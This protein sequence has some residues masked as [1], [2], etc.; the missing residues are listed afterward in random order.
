MD[1]NFYETVFPFKSNSFNKEFVFEKNETNDLNFFDEIKE[2]S[3]ESNEPNDDR[4]DS[5][6]NGNKSAPN[7]NSADVIGNTSSR[8]DTSENE[9]VTE[10]GV[11]EGIYS[12]KLDDDD[13]YE[14]D[15]FK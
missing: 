12:T 3:L 1:V 9:Y 7:K 2:S 10:T 15:E 11:S 8:K 5:A 14:S 13:E 4:G 6:V